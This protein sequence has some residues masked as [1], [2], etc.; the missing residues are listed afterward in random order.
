MGAEDEQAKPGGTDVRFNWI[1]DRTCSSLK[2]KEDSFQRLLASESRYNV[3]SCVCDV[4][5]EA[6]LLLSVEWCLAV[7]LIFAQVLVAMHR[8]PLT[9]FL[10]DPEV[11]R[12]MIYMDGKDLTAVC[13]SAMLSQ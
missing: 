11:L 12:L 2:V 7:D 4:H 3:C 5:L 10:E 9:S 6:P 1:S 13:D 8:G